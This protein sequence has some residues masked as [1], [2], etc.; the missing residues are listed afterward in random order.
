[1]LVL[2]R[3]LAA[4]IHGPWASTDDPTMMHSNPDASISH[5]LFF[6]RRSLLTGLAH[7]F[8]GVVLARIWTVA[9][10]SSWYGRYFVGRRTQP[11]SEKSGAATQEMSKT[12]ADIW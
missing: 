11:S 10:C 7:F 4:P 6:A 2:P 12:D 1:M 8:F 3:T 9:K 5:M